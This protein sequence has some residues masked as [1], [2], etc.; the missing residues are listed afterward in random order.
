[1]AR[2]LDEGRRH[3]AAVSDGLSLRLAIQDDVPAIVKLIDASVRGLSVNYYSGA[4]I[5]QALLHVFGPDT[6]LIADRTYFVIES[7]T[8]DIAASG[9]WSKRRT[10]YGGDQHK[11]TGADPLLDPIVDA[12]RIRAFF[13]HPGYARR[14]LGR[15]VFEACRA[16][17]EA[18]GFKALELG[19]TLPGVPFYERLGFKQIERADATLPEGALQIV[20]MRRGIG[21]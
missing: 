18:A 14:G 16:S 17:A 7:P 19:A 4:Q 21:R 10:L 20:R 9:G 8:D 1:M 5:D 15:R 3:I 6:Q 11:G 13:V 12:A 2:S